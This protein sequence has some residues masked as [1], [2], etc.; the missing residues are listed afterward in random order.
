[1]SRSAAFWQWYARVSDD[2]RHEVV[3]RAWF[4]REVTGDIDLG[5]QPAYDEGYE[6]STST[7][8]TRTTEL[9]GAEAYE[10]VWGRQVEMAD[11]YGESVQEADPAIEHAPEPPMIEQEP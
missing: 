11:L 5:K 10:S 1:M 6:I 2:V 9:Y 3:E 8:V 4:G 7:E